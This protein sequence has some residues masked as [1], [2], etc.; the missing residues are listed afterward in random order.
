[1]NL[2]LQ[3][4]VANFFCKFLIYMVILAIMPLF[5]PKCEK[6]WAFF[7]LQKHKREHIFVILSFFIAIIYYDLSYYANFPT[8]RRQI[9]V[10]NILYYWLTLAIMSTNRIVHCKTLKN[11]V[12]YWN[13]VFLWQWSRLNNHTNCKFQYPHKSHI[14]L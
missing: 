5:L 12:L 3:N 9:I 1:M 10:E 14:S 8:N 13:I 6:C 7:F 11:G 2:I 4:I